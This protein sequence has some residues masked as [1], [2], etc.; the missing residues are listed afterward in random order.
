MS[1]RQ[2]AETSAGGNLPTIRS[3]CSLRWLTKC[4]VVRATAFRDE[5][6]LATAVGT[7]VDSSKLPC[8]NVWSGVRGDKFGA[9]L[10]GKYDVHD[11]PKFI[12][13]SC[14]LYKNPAVCRAL[15]A[16]C[17][18]RKHRIHTNSLQH[19]RLLHSVMQFFGLPLV[20]LAVTSLIG[21]V[22][23]QDGDPCSPSGTYIAHF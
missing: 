6:K 18:S 3:L 16:S 19:I 10:A 23:G 13:A 9:C 11:H 5:K 15:S 21:V 8:S 22:N 7:R 17:N 1:L 4:D 14:L 2:E 12:S 20:A